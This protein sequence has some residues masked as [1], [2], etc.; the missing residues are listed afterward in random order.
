MRWLDQLKD[1]AAALKAGRPVSRPAGL[2][3]L[4]IWPG[5]AICIGHYVDLT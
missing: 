2:V 5:L 1:N 4:T 3:V